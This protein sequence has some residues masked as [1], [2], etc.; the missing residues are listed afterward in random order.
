MSRVKYLAL[1][2]V[3]WYGTLYGLLL[4]LNKDCKAA[5]KKE[6]ELPNVK[7]EVINNFH[8][9]GMPSFGYVGSDYV[10][11][12][13]HIKADNQQQY[14]PLETVTYVTHGQ[15]A[16]FDNLGPLMERWQAPLSIAVFAPGSDYELAFKHAQYYRKCS[17]HNQLIADNVSFHFF[18]P[19]DH[20]SPSIHEVDRDSPQLDCD[21]LT[22]EMKRLF[23]WG[24]LTELILHLCLILRRHSENSSYSSLHQMDYPINAARVIARRC[25]E[26]QFV[27][28]SDIELYPSPGLAKGFIQMVKNNIGNRSIINDV[29]YVI[30]VFEM[31]DS[32]SV[33]VPADKEE[34]RTMIANKTAF[35]FHHNYCPICHKVPNFEEWLSDKGDLTNYHTY[36]V[37]SRENKN[38]FCNIFFLHNK[39]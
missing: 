4:F 38:P 5:K 23:S 6:S 30:P 34:L 28:L 22:E 29:A 14:G 15:Y 3:I 17:Q 36:Y 9:Q 7:E 26:T 1:R 13:N 16:Y 18:F 27:L 21:R 25:A 35:T 20:I 31:V 11:L 37:P 24:L 19:S 12:Y 39:K 32:Q 2:F 8:L 33:T 10:V